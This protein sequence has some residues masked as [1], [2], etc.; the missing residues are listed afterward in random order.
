M[1]SIELLLV[2]LDEVEHFRL[3]DAEFYDNS[4]FK[5]ILGDQQDA[6][7]SGLN[8]LIGIEQMFATEKF[9]FEETKMFNHTE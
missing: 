5:V 9:Y 1:S 3:T 8:Q 6:R 7:A 4:L 2:S